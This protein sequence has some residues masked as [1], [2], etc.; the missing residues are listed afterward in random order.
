MSRCATNCRL[1]EGSEA[2]R[3]ARAEARAEARGEARR[4]GSL[5]SRK[6]ER[7]HATHAHRRRRR[8]R[9]QRSSSLP[10]SS[11]PRRLSGPWAA[12]TAPP[13][14]PRPLQLQG[15]VAISGV[16]YQ[17][18]AASPVRVDSSTVS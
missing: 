11:P 12:A 9:W 10:L 4:G 2:S 13:R 16:V 15:A 5:A 6:A 17:P 1:P 14:E 8:R 3:E 18:S 7:G